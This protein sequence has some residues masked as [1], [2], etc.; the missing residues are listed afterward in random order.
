VDLTKP[1]TPFILSVGEKKSKANAPF[2]RDNWGTGRFL[3][4]VRF[5]NKRPSGE[6]IHKPGELEQTLTA[7]ARR[8]ANGGAMTL[9]IP[10]LRIHGRIYPVR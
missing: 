1:E 9:S 8:Y 3:L 4:W 7:I 2:R 5:E 6:R 10:W